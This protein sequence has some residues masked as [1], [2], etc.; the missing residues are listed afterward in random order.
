MRGGER[1]AREE[2]VG[3]D[4]R[5]GVG[6]VGGPR[7]GG[8]SLLLNQTMSSAR[9]PPGPTLQAPAHPS[10]VSPSRGLTQGLTPPIFQVL[11]FPGPIH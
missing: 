2:F 8:A 5:A 7:S 3:E 10:S 11:S 4:E 6:T 9:C 1:G